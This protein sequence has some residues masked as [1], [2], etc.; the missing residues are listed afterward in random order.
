MAPIVGGLIGQFLGWR[1][2]FKFAA[3]QGDASHHHIILPPR[4][5][6]HKRRNSFGSHTVRARSRIHPKDVCFSIKPKLHFPGIKAKMESVNHPVTKYGTIS[7]GSDSLTVLRGAIWICLNS[8]CCYG[9]KY[10]L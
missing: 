6:L 9:G 2:T 10:L 7:V 5:S 8:P 1:W 3:L 4:N